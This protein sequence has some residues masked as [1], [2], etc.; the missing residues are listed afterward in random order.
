MKVKTIFKLT[1]SIIICQLPGIIGGA[2]TASSVN[3][4]YPALNKPWFNPPSWVFAPVWTALYLLMGISLFLIWRQVSEG[5]RAKEAL[6]AFTTQLIFNGLWSVA[7]FGGRSP[8]G[9]LL[10]I[11]F[12]WIFIY[13]SIAEFW[14]ISKPAAMLLL[15]YIVWV[16]FAALLNAAMVVM[17]P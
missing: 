5:I 14:K 3:T 13:W 9:G 4:W 8:A 2:F 10:V 6:I 16:S 1:A 12:L 15:P 17:N 7:F 11:A